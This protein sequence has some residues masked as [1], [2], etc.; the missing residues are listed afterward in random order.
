MEDNLEKAVVNSEVNSSV[1]PKVDHSSNFRKSLV[2]AKR[3]NLQRNRNLSLEKHRFRINEISSSVL[4]SLKQEFQGFQ[5]EHPEAIGLT[6][7]GSQVK[8]TAKE[9]SDVDC[10]LFVDEEKLTDQKAEDKDT[11]I[12][13]KKRVRSVVSPSVG[14]LKDVQIHML[15]KDGIDTQVDSL[16]GFYDKL[17]VYL[18]NGGEDPEQPDYDLQ[19]LFHMQIGRGLDEYRRYIIDRFEQ[20]GDPGKRAFDLIMG[21]LEDWEGNDSLNEELFPKDFQKA[22]KRFNLENVKPKYE[23]VPEPKVASKN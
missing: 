17:D 22:I 7:Y 4:G 15:S 8:G 21:D 20:S 12:P 10:F 13:F 2:K 5:Q 3:S 16:V 14:T 11:I 18:K 9:S 19:D 1:L 6:V 23:I